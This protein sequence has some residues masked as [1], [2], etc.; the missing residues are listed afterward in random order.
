MA[1]LFGGSS[2]PPP[3]K[4]TRLPTQNNATLIA[5][6]RRARA[7]VRGRR[8]RLSTVLSDGLRSLTGSIGKLGR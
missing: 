7:A 2:A 1:G 6:Q 3:P 4:P 8:G 5:A